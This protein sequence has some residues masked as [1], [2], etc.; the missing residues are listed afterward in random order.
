MV[1]LICSPPRSASSRRW[2]WTAAICAIL[3]TSDFFR[4]AELRHHRQFLA[5]QLRAPLPYSFPPSTTSGTIRGNINGSVQAFGRILEMLDQL[6]LKLGVAVNV[7]CHS[8]GNYM[9][10]LGMHAQPVVQQAILN[11]VLLVAADINN[12]ALLPSSITSSD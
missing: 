4:L 9:M 6:R 10:M 3:R 12:G 2:E 8:E 1:S 7:I 11:Q 5:T